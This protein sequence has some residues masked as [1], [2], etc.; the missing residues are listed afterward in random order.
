M[1]KKLTGVLMKKFLIFVM[2]VFMFASF[3]RA[4]LTVGN[5]TDQVQ[6]NYEVNVSVPISILDPGTLRFPDI[7]PGSTNNYTDGQYRMEFRISGGAGLPVHITGTVD[8]HG[9][10]ND[11][12]LTYTW[13]GWING[14]W[15]AI[16]N[17]G[18]PWSTTLD[19]AGIVII[20]VQPN[21]LQANTDATAGTKSF[22]ITVTATYGA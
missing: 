9:T 12:L 4:Q 6:S 10:S 21:S 16:P 18:L 15:A 5:N 14:A 13:V 22:Q 3:A 19:G 7:A 1:F 20:G 11:C 17:G 8:I 2:S